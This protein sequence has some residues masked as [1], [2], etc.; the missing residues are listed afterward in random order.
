MFKVNNANQILFLK[1][2]LKDINMD[3]GESIQSYVMRITQIK[4]DLLSIGEVIADKEL[5][6]IALGGLS[7][8]WDVFTITILNNDKI[9]GFDELL[10]T[11]TQEEM[12]DD[13]ERQA[14]KWK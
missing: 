9:H 12:R 2:K 7:R 6:L 13:G 14:F 5:T 10:A 8:P 1:N 3:K 4:N 11:C